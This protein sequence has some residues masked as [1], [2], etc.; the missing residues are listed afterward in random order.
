MNR[1]TIFC[2]RPMTRNEAIA[3]WISIGVVIFTSGG[4]LFG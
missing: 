3:F 1:S 4:A 2:N